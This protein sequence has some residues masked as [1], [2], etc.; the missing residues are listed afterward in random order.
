M[1]I[2]RRFVLTG[3][4]SAPAVIAADRLMPVRSIVKR[5]ATVY[6]VGHDLEVIEWIAWSSEDALRFANLRGPIEMFREVTDIVY[7]FDMPPLPEPA[8]GVH[9]EKQVDPISAANVAVEVQSNGFSNVTSYSKLNEWRDSLRPDY[10]G[11]L[12]HRWVQEQLAAYRKFGI[13]PF[14]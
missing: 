10:D 13:D 3:M 4:I 6:G 2:S 12:D 5:Y 14:G 8:T 9:Q 7:G 1:L 11:H